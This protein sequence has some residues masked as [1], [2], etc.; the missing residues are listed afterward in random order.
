MVWSLVSLECP[1][2]LELVFEDPLTGDNIGTAGSQNQVPSV[3]GH[4]G[5]ILFL[6]SRPPM[7]ID[8]GGPN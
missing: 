6:H 2:D 8:E 5:G 4:E 3:I 7:R 1:A